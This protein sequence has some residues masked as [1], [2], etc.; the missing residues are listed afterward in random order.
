MADKWLSSVSQ[1]VSALGEQLRKIEAELASRDIKDL[2]TA[3]LHSLA[4]HLRC[5]IE[6]TTG[7]VQLTSPVGEIPGDEFHDQVQARHSIQRRSDET[8][9]RA[10]YR[11]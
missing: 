2:S 9:L 11:V 10:A 6:Q 7:T 3:Q 5:Q 4:R 8:P 1:R